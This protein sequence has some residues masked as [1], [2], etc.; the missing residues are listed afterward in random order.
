MASGVPVM[1]VISG[2]AV[3]VLRVGSSVM[4]HCAVLLLVWN[5]GPPWLVAVSI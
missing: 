1:L 2:V 4:L 3:S 5:V